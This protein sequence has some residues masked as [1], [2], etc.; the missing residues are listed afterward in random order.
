MYKLAL[1]IAWRNLWKNKVFS[2]INIG[3]LAIGLASC[4]LLLLYV[5]YEWSFDK[6]FKNINRIYSV[7]END[8]MSDKVTTNRSY[9]TPSQLAATAQQTIPGIEYVCRLVEGGGLLNYKNN[10]FNK[11][12][13]YTDPS[14]LKM[15]DYQFIKG[16]PVTALSSPGSVLITEETAKVF[17][18]DEEPIGKTLKFDNRVPLTVTAVIKNLPVNQSYRFDLL[19]TWSF[20]EK[21]Q[22]YLKRMDW[23]D[24]ALNTLIQLKDKSSFAAADTQMRKIFMQKQNGA[25]YI[26]FFLFPFEKNH[27]YTSFENGKLVGGGIDQVKLYLILAASVLFIGC[28]NYMNLSTARSEKRAREVGVR[29][30]LGSSRRAIIWQFLAE[31]LLLSSL[32]M[33]IAF[34]LLEISLPYFNHLLGI[35]MSINY[36]SYGIWTILILLIVF[37]GFLAGSYPA[38]YLS[39]FMPVKVLKGFKGTGENTL[40]IRK[41]LVII[42]FGFSICMIVCAIVVH[43]QTSYMR[44]KPLGFNKD[45]LVQLWRPGALRDAHKLDLFKAELMKSGAIVAATETA[46]GVTNNAVSTEKIRWPEQ[47]KDE[48]IKMQLHFSGY[49]FAKTIGTEMLVGRDFNQ[50]FGNDTLSVVLNETA[51]KT[52]NLKNPIGAKIRND[53]WGRTFTV[54]GII[55]DYVYS[56]LG[57]KVEPSLYFYRT[58]EVVNVIVLRLNPAM[59]MTSSI[60]KIKALSLKINPGYPLEITFVSQRMAEKLQN[61][62]VL[63]ILSKIFGGFAIFISCLGLLGLALYVAEQ[64]S[65][66]ISIRKVLGADLRNILILL[67]RDFIKLVIISNF[68]SIPVAYIVAYQWLQKYDYRIG[69]SY[70]PFLTALLLSVFIAILSVSLQTF[71]VARSNPADA[72]K[73][74]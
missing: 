24:G 72:L 42:Q 27:L 4:L 58:D 19:S 40:S 47:Q 37:T 29:K 68:V 30:S 5:N 38:F 23:S 22:P 3:G 41:M 52:M 31:S 1:K 34:I 43:Q 6:Q 33:V 49:D 67:N 69:I 70:L 36:S 57:A 65:K 20:L 14:F 55:K 32:A 25:K 46:N 53:D 10:S 17:F 44:T 48:Q 61:E 8:R 28:I 60:E 54:I 51:V 66:E 16:D 50:A 35:E 63:S 56:S 71:K 9:A 15:F 13:I 18:G 2:L 39:S 59:N 62:K 45:N 11:K 74:E 26:E 12:I 64:R 73:Y 7:Y 21:E